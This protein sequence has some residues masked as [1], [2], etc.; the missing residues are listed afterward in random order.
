M[1]SAQGALLI[2]HELLNSTSLSFLAGWVIILDKL[3]VELKIRGYSEATIKHYLRHNRAFLAFSKKQPEKITTSDVKAFMAYLIADK[4]Q[5]PSSV[6]LAIS[7]LK[8]FYETVLKR[9][10]FDDIKPPKLEKKIPT[11]LSREEITRMI[12]TCKNVKHR[13]LIELLYSSGLRVSEA[14]NMKV[15]DLDLD[16]HMGKVISGKGKKD[17]HI[18][19]SRALVQDL[20]AY[21]ASRTKTSP[22]VFSDPSGEHP[23]VV[24]MAQKIVQKAAKKAGITKRVFCHALR[25]SFATH[26]LEQGTDIRIIQELL[27]HSNLST[28]ERYTK[29][30]TEQLKKVVSPYDR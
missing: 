3:N 19:L 11:V 26:L 22:Y 14:V 4:H 6:G 10:I 30:S 17:R 13:L 12:E 2:L 18:I 28:T 1:V 29:V 7:S 5:K 9:K 8:F 20:R 21:F 23:L 27:G 16:E 24:R 15:E 25:S